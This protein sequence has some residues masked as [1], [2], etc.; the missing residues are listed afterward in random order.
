[1]NLCE[2]AGSDENGVLVNVNRRS[3]GRPEVLSAVPGLGISP[4]GRDDSR[5]AV[6]MTVE[7]RS[8]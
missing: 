5:G 6:E 1:M 2:D 8:R 7:V 3:A 4:C